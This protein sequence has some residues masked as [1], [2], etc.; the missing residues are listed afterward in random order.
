M[1]AVRLD[2]E[3]TKGDVDLYV[4]L[5]DVETIIEEHLNKVLSAWLR[6]QRLNI[7]LDFEDVVAEMEGAVGERQYTYRTP[8]AEFFDIDNETG[9]ELEA[10]L[11]VGLEVFR[12][13]Y[14]REPGE[15]PRHAD[16]DE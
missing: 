12:D 5:S 16:E 7:Y 6:E 8:F 1:T 10:F 13:R 14:E 15:R 9:G 2:P 3:T 4:N 11:L